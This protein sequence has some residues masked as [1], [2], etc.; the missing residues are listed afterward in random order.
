MST[1]LANSVSGFLSMYFSEK[2]ESKVVL[3][4]LFEEIVVVFHTFLRGEK[5]EVFPLRSAG[6]TILKTVDVPLG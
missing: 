4:K 1:L 6:C 5:T 3:K 2:L